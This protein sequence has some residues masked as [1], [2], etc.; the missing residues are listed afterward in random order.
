VNQND[1]CNACRFWTARRECRRFP[2]QLTTLGNPHS[3]DAAS[4]W[5]I[6]RGFDWC[7]EFREITIVREVTL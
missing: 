5:P 3:L 2:P 7:G 4:L 6:T 1:A